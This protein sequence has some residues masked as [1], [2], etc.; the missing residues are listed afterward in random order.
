MALS[1]LQS[2]A[3]PSRADQSYSRLHLISISKEVL[4]LLES[5]QLQSKLS[6][7]LN[8]TRQ[9]YD[10]FVLLLQCLE[11]LFIHLKLLSSAFFRAN[12]LFLVT[13]L[14]ERY[15][16]QSCSCLPGFKK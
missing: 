11:H 10:S 14:V 3:S 5:H 15:L 7:S 1:F 9:L 6:S 16:L 8:Q 12:F 4:Q 2:F 13:S